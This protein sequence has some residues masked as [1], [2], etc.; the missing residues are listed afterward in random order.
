MSFDGDVARGRICPRGQTKLKLC[1]FKYL[2]LADSELPIKFSRD[3]GGCM[4]LQTAKSSICYNELSPQRLPSLLCLAAIHKVLVLK[5]A[6]ASFTT[7]LL[8]VHSTRG[9]PQNKRFGGAW[10][11]RDSRAFSSSSRQAGEG[12]RAAI[13]LTNQRGLGGRASARARRGRVNQCVLSAVRTRPRAL[14][15]RFRPDGARR[16]G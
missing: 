5:S 9:P 7:Q 6:R 3:R 8:R 1:R 13:V 14:P 11:N 4:A 16:F 15:N 10:A 12:G 2:P